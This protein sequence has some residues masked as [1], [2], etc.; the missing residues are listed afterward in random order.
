MDR[1]CVPRRAGDDR[2]YSRMQLGVA[3][4]VHTVNRNAGA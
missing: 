3:F 4:V 1:D 2:Q